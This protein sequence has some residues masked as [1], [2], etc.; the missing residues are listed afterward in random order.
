MGIKMP[1]SVVYWTTSTIKNEKSAA[2]FHY[3]K[4]VSGKVV[5]HSIAFR[6]VS[7]YWQ[8]DDPFPLKPCLQVTCPLL[9]V[10]SYENTAVVCIA[11]VLRVGEGRSAVCISSSLW[12]DDT[13]RTHRWWLRAGTWLSITGGQW[14]MYCIVL[15]GTAFQWQLNKPCCLLRVEGYLIW[16]SKSGHSFVIWLSSFTKIVA[17]DY[18]KCIRQYTC[19]NRCYE[20]LWYPYSY[21]S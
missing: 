6:V 21:Y 11:C 2:K 12:S 1:W 14:L 18:D 4:T 16:L 15:S 20:H 3:I 7:I 5:E 8:G 10:V 13:R 9:S 17:V 19:S